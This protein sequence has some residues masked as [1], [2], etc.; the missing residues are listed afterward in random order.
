[1]CGIFGFA[2]NNPISLDKVFRLLERLEVHQNNQEPTPVGG[3]GAGV[4]ILEKDG[5]I[6]FEKVGKVSDSPARSLAE[7]VEAKVTEAAVLIAHV[8]RPSPG[9]MKSA[10]FKE[11]AQPYVVQRDPKLSVVSVHNGKVENYREI[12]EKLGKDHVLESEKV[13]LIDSEVI[14]HFFEEILNEKEDVDEA[15]YTLL[16]ALQGSSAIGM[17]QIEEEN[18]FLHIMHKGKTRGLTIWTNGR[19]EVMFCSREE[20]VMEEFRRLLSSRRFEKK[21][22]IGYHED[23]GLKLS[24]PLI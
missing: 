22:Q 2:L 23:A 9:F 8:R 13:E 11:T 16:C 7:I 15:S 21:I 17:L 24:F 20:P 12:R 18:A 3:Y 4:A 14:P 19:N 6:V 1:M 10:K 5:S